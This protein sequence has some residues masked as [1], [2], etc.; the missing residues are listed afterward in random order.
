M[1]CSTSIVY[2]CGGDTAT[3]Q[4]RISNIGSI[5][6]FTTK[7]DILFYTKKN[8]ETQSSSL[9]VLQVTFVEILWNV[10]S[11]E[12]LALS[13]KVSATDSRNI[14]SKYE[15]ADIDEATEVRSGT[16]Y[17]L[18]ATHTVSA[19]CRRKIGFRQPRQRV[20]TSRRNYTANMISVHRRNPTPRDITQLL[21][22]FDWYV[23]NLTRFSAQLK[24][25]LGGCWLSSAQEAAIS[26]IIR[27]VLSGKRTHCWDHYNRYN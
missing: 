17:A 18:V 11:A 24:A 9:V 6:L 7:H 26:A 19:F 21:F 20:G 10:L 5:A 13:M 22:T 4:P 3:Y 15:W 27:S 14:V 23:Q 1:R 16:C 2:V 12:A 8:I 25:R